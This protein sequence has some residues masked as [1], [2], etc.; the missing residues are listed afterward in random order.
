M[1]LDVNHNV[2]LGQILVKEVF[3]KK[4]I[5]E[6][7]ALE[8][9]KKGITLGQ[10]LI[11]KGLVGETQLAKALA[12]QKGFPY[13]N[14]RDYPV[15]KKAL[16]FLS[17]SDAVKFGVL[18]LSVEGDTLY[19]A[20][21]DPLDIVTVDSLSYLAHMQIKLA[22]SEKSSIEKAIEQYYPSDDVILILPGEE[23]VEDEVKKVEKVSS[24]SIRFVNQIIGS[25]ISMRASDIHFEP[26]ERRTAIRF[27]IDGVLQEVESFP[28]SEHASVI[29]RIKV[30][31]NLD[32]AERRRP[33][34]GSFLMK[35]EGKRIDVRVSILP[36]VS[37]EVATL[38][39]L[40]QGGFA[41]ELSNL[42][43]NPKVLERYLET[44]LKPTGFILNTGPTGSGKTTTLYATLKLVSTPDKKLV[45][46]EDPVEYHLPGVVQLQVNRKAGLT[47]AS[48]LRSILRAD[49][50][51]IMVGEVRDLETVEVA[52]QAALTGHL[53]FSTLHTNGAAGSITRLLDIG[54]PPFLINSSITGI[55]AQRL[56]R[57]LCL[58]CR[59]SYEPDEDVLR[60]LHIDLD[61][62][63]CPLIYRAKGCSRC[64][65]TGYQGRIGLFELLIMSPSI[66][67]AVLERKSARE[68]SEIAN[69]EGMSTLFEDGI[70]KVKE[71]LTSVEELLR[72]IH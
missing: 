23:G 71:G 60:M 14:L 49:P 56:V 13:L 43:F 45:T 42:G 1:T 35:H 52:I 7:A 36:S 6:E 53:V 4:D 55:L 29:S 63:S 28:R 65:G 15:E 12:K 20:T 69:A 50:D 44:I 72:V 2:R 54:V 38:R 17:K 34:D 64:G 51:I 48:G 8:S 16:A 40:K 58:N 67:N 70:E 61:K 46:I 66:S 26:D 33:Q 68:I 3:I 11:Q 27:R 57:R 30:M 5:L 32:I 59:E 19:V 47:F 24:K 21:S 25:A 9:Q 39:L 37:G 10:Y 41:F 62:K 31:A 18:P 22:V